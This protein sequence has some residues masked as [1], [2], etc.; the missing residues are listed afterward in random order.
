MHPAKQSNV[1]ICLVSVQ[2]NQHPST[3]VPLLT[4]S[5][6]GSFSNN[7]TL[8]DVVGNITHSSILVPYHGESG[9]P[10]LKSA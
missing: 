5:G 4:C 6:H 7:K 9:L 8:N 1:T 2:S 3:Q 10:G